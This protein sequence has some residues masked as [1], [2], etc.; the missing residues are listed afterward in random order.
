[1]SNGLSLTLLAVNIDNQCE[2][3]F[4]TCNKVSVHLYEPH[5]TRR[6]NCTDCSR[7][8]SLAIVN[9]QRAKR[10]KQRVYATWDHLA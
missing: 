8:V 4:L 3:A 5:D 7:I 2:L 1:M 6:M 10:A 9:L